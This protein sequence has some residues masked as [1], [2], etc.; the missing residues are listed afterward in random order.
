MRASFASL[1][2]WAS[3]K[4][5][6]AGW[7]NETDSRGVCVYICVY[8][9]C[10]VHILL[11]TQL[12]F[13]CTYQLL[14]LILWE[15]LLGWGQVAEAFELGRELWDNHQESCTLASQVKAAVCCSHTTEGVK[16]GLEKTEQTVSS[17][18]THDCCWALLSPSLSGEDLYFFLL[19]FSKHDSF[20]C[21]K[22]ET[23]NEKRCLVP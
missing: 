15:F 14:A 7:S 21:T 5:D 16:Q 4:C 22:G 11:L 20:S 10:T 17:G 1:F 12:K 2:I 6:I 13:T 3:D 23:T 8:I 9:T 19:A 18:I